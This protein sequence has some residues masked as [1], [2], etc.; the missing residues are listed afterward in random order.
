MGKAVAVYVR[1]EDLPLW[2]RAERYARERRMP[3]SGVV[4][5]AVERFLD[6]EDPPAR[7]R[8]R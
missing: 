3:V 7:P 1:E 6:E 4:L 8:R 2:E 5:L